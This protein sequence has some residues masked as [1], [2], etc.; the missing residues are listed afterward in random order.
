MTLEYCQNS[1][2][3]RTKTKNLNVSR[4]AL[5]LSLPNPMKLR[6]KLRMMQLELRRPFVQAYIKVHLNAP[7][8][9]LY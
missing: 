2:I 3:N 1:S 6:V 5:Q 7:L 4:V 8:L 9:V